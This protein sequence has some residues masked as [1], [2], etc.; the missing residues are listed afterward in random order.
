MYGQLHEGIVI[1][2]ASS[3]ILYVNDRV[4]TITGYHRDE[5]ISNNPHLLSSGKHDAEFYKT[6]WQHLVTNGYWHGEIYNKKKNGEIYAEWLS[7]TT[8]MD[9]HGT[10]Y[11]IGM[12]IE[13]DPAI[14]AVSSHSSK[15]EEVTELVMKWQPLLQSYLPIVTEKIITNFLQTTQASTGKDEQLEL[16]SEAWRAEIYA[17]LSTIFSDSMT[18]EEMIKSAHQYGERLVLSGFQLQDMFKL[19][20]IQTACIHDTLDRFSLPQEEKSALITALQTRSHEEFIQRLYAMNNVIH[21][22]IVPDQKSNDQLMTWQEIKNNV[23]QYIANLPGMIGL[24]LYRNLPNDKFV[25]EI[26]V[27]NKDHEMQGV[28][29]IDSLKTY[30]EQIIAEH[31]VNILFK[32]A[33]ASHQTDRMITIPDYEK[34]LCPEE[35]APVLKI[36][37]RFDMRS[38]IFIPIVHPIHKQKMTI[39][40]F[41]RF[42]N[43]FE[44]SWIHSF[45]LSLRK[46]IEQQWILHQPTPT[47]SAL[48]QFTAHAYRHRLFHGGLAL[49][50]QPIIDTV[51]GSLQ[52]V[53]ILARLKL[54]DGTIVSPFRFLPLL[55]RQEL[56]TLFQ[57]ELDIALAYLATF[58]DVTHEVGVTINLPP[59]T[60][61]NNDCVRW[62]QAAMASSQ[63]APHLLTLEILEDHDI[64]FTKQEETI[65][66]L[67]QIG[68]QI[69]I[70]DLGSGYSSLLRLSSLPI[71]VIKIDQGLTSKLTQNPNTVVNIIHGLIRIGRGMGCEI[72]VEGIENEEYLDAIKML[73]P[74]MVQGYAIA[75]PMPIEE[76][77]DWYQAY[78]WPNH[79]SHVKTPLGALAYHFCF[80]QDE[81]E[82][83]KFSVDR[84][85]L[86]N[87]LGTHHEESPDVHQWHHDLHKRKQFHENRIRITS[88]LE[89]KVKEQDR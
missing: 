12:F 43:Q 79:L 66:Q 50:G 74:T 57:R 20:D 52:K 10:I 87:Y 21:Q 73:R 9:E 68:V 2:D 88:W 11:Y 32:N 59:L 41:G 45:T 38:A 30:L 37:R 3:T 56:D 27:S 7:I 55:S 69:A 75:K 83:E 36:V 63:I 8:S 70:D 40:L 42:P 67:K 81:H 78:E 86:T 13:I 31:D 53:E 24:I 62:V 64:H 22:F 19:Y 5:L 49:Y 72:V 39:S 34:L 26:L 71:D 47:E 33:I 60:L 51:T 84:C 1:T 48:D 80:E 89:N 16:A 29:Q 65:H 76:I 61:L 28:I 85:P 6:T 82:I 18:H 44:S 14:N 58:N 77:F 15:T 46:F 35:V 54:E 4:L 23:M 25:P 17:I